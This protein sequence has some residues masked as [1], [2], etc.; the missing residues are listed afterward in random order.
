MPEVNQI[1]FSH[2]ELVEFFSRRLESTKEGGC[3]LQT[4]DFQRGIL[5]RHRTNFRQE[6]LWL[7]FKWGSQEQARKF[8]SKLY[9]MQQS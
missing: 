3:S 9:Q 5:V 8:P 7:S 2:K 1:F 4:L 6:V